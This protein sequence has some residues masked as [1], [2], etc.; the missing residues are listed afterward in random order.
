M[1][2]SLR[3]CTSLLFI[4]M[5]VLTAMAAAETGVTGRLTG[6]VTDP[7]GAVLANA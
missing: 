4:T 7:Q 1:R 2:W 3:L 5:I 6:V